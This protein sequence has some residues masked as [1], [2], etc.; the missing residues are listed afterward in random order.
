MNEKGKPRRLFVTARQLVALQ[1]SEVLGG[2]FA[3]NT[4]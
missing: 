2:A 3:L 1:Q 4:G